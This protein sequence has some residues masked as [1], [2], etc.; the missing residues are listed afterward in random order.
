MSAEILYGGPVADEIDKKTKQIVQALYN[1][2]V[3]AHLSMI[4]I[5]NEP[6]D[7]SYQNAIMKRC[8]KLGLETSLEV[9]PK[10]V[11][12]HT[13]TT[14]LGQL[15]SDVDVSGI[16]V[17]RPVPKKLNEFTICE[18]VKAKKDVDGITMLS[19][20][21]VYTGKNV[22]YPPCTAEACMRMLQYY[23]IP[24]DGK[25]VVVLGR[26]PV[27]GRPV[28]MMLLRANATVTIC[29][30]HTVNLAEELRKA[31]IIIAAAGS[32]RMVGRDCVSP[33]Q[34][35]LDVGINWLEDEQKIVGDVDF[36]AVVDIVGAISPVPGGIGNIS[37]AMLVSHTAEAARR[38]VEFAY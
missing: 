29:H 1:Y 37:S 34:I 28:S 24:L 33:G 6:D 9:F 8:E 25:K 10:D 36:D 11:E 22:G 20:G 19:S 32:P 4:R 12:Q 13:I 14:K 2:N 23:K 38:T 27:I 3:V 18:A 26:S 16:L 17:F 21:G 30:S 15:N 5:G 35:I 31:D 7:I